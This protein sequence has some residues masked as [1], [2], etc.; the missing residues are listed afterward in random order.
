MTLNKVLKRV[1]ALPLVTWLLMAGCASTSY[2]EVTYQLPQPEQPVGP[3]TVFLQVVDQRTTATIAGP[4]AQK[5]LEDFT[6]LFSLY[7]AT[8]GQK[9]D[10]IGAFD[11][12]A[13][14]KEALQRRLESEGVTVLAPQAADQP[15]L[16]IQLQEFVLDREGK[17]WKA[18]LAYKAVTSKGGR[19]LTNQNVSGSAERLKIV[20]TRD[21]EKLLGEIFSDM[22]NKLDPEKLFNHPDL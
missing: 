7:V 2:I 3:K 8:K 5:E 9:P 21:A 19:I 1:V 6:G 17:S 15:L 11:L 10:L 16:E 4:N 22:V 14:F 12:A 13:L 18:N 20:G